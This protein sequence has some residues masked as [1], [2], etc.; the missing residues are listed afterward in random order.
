M[1][2]V[3][4]KWQVLLRSKRT[5]QQQKHPSLPGQGG[6][7]CQLQATEQGW[8]NF[9]FARQTCSAAAATGRPKQLCGSLCLL[10][11]TL[12]NFRTKAC[13][14]HRFYRFCFN[15]SCYPSW[16]LVGNP[17]M[18]ALASTLPDGRDGATR[19]W[20]DSNSCYFSCNMLESN[21]LLLCSHNYRKPSAE[22]IPGIRYSSHIP[23][24][25]G[26]PSIHSIRG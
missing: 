7:W 9:S 23:R 12:W 4:F 3:V 19:A 26:A 20:P 10:R 11:C 2:N 5:L 14:S 1:F 24:P 16:S 6:L 17:T 13:L 21:Y 8:Y 22:C 25:N 18:L 15:Q